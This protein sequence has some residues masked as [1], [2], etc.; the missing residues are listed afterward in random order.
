[1]LQAGAWSK[2]I[3]LSGRCCSAAGAGHSCISR[4]LCLAIWQSVG[5]LTK[6]G[7][8]KMPQQHV[9][10]AA[11]RNHVARPFP[12]SQP[13]QRRAHSHKSFRIDGSRNVYVERCTLFKSDLNTTIKTKSFR[14][15]ECGTVPRSPV[16]GG[17]GRATE[18]RTHLQPRKATAEPERRNRERR[19][20]PVP[21]RW[22]PRGGGG[23]VA[24]R[25]HPPAHTA[26]ENGSRMPGALGQS[27]GSLLLS[28]KSD[29]RGT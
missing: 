22:C 29:H 19:A 23:G 27:S 18:Q 12:R 15:E 26:R 10:T 13:S 3:V 14:N 21:R 16:T 4:E 11:R 1:M 25:L 8:Q 5:D 7:N 9:G 28:S 2:A 17:T 20:S 6:R 24:A